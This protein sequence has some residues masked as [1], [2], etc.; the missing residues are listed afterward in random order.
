MRR[1]VWPLVIMAALV[2]L[3]GFFA[4]RA[5]AAPA[6]VDGLPQDAPQDAQEN[7]G[8]A[9]DGRVTLVAVGDNSPNDNVGA[10]AD[11]LAGDIGDDQYDYAPIYSDLAPR[12]QAADLAFVNEETCIGGNEIGPRGYPNFNTTDEMADAL[13]A[14]GF[15]LVGTANNHSYDWGRYGA[16]EHSVEVWEQ[17]PVTF[18]GTSASREQYESIATR[19]C[20][21][22]TFALL[23][24]TYG[25]NGYESVV[26]PYTVNL[27][28]AGRITSDVERAHEM[29]DVVLVA[30]HWGVEHS[31]TP[32]DEQRKLAQMLAD[33]DVDLVIG[34]H[35]HVMQPMEWVE[36]SDG[37]G[38]RTLVTYS[39]GNFMH[40]HAN[41]SPEN[42]L[43][44]MFGCDFVRQDDGTVA[45]EN[46]SWTPLVHHVN[47]SQTEYA[48]YAA[49]DYTPELAAEN[50]ALTQLDDP[51]SWLYD[52]TRE[53][54]GTDWF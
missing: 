51:I 12:V 35:P 15:N 41:P 53:I 7:A 36:N 23:N 37:S 16:V 21:G 2:L 40:D 38:H 18:T 28:D 52:R 24:Y 25:L 39:L 10:Y 19:E 33:L 42:V 6:A 50:R 26:P 17:Q 9:T 34:A 3:V 30:M 27:I 11:S 44:G 20:N 5:C 31:T 54:V 49:D 48:V 13:V 47:A 22:I 46:V 45:L 4:F 8:A 43:E 14:T 1:P 32:S 29:A